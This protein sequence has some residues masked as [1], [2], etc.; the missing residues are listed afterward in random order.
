V[1]N[2][3]GVCLRA[4]AEYV[5]GITEEPNREVGGVEVAGFGWVTRGVAAGEV[6]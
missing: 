6:V 5:D 2:K 4:T 3:P 1:C